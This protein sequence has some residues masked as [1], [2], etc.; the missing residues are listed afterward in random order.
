MTNIKDVNGY[1]CYW[2]EK[3]IY[4]FSK[5]T[6]KGP[7]RYSTI[8]CEEEQLTNGDIEFMTLN[9]LTLSDARKKAYQKKFTNDI[10]K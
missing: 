10:K 7:T 2:I 8:E 3:G 4:S 9:G 5:K 6:P 1:S